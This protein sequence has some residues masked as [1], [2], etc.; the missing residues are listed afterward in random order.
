M[1]VPIAAGLVLGAGLWPNAHG[2]GTVDRDLAAPP[3]TIAIEDDPATAPGQPGLPGPVST[4]TTATATP[5]PSTG[6]DLEDDFSDRLS[7]WGEAVN[8]KGSIGYA[9]GAYQVTINQPNRG[10]FV[11]APWADVPANVTIE[12]DA[13]KTSGG[14]GSFGVACRDDAGLR[15]SALVDINTAW[16]ITRIDVA[17]A[18]PRRLVSGTTTAIQRSGT[19]HVAFECKGGSAHSPVDLTLYVNG[20][21]VGHVLDADGLGTGRVGVEVASGTQAVSVAFDDIVA[22]EP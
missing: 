9:Q 19:N 20:Q 2:G 11:P 3:S 13:T 5:R 6:L 4:L 17:G 18:Q 21:K 15:Y 1:L 22:G 10:T 16:R 14:L 12:V 7:G 8:P